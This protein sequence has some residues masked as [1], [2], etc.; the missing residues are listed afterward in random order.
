MVRILT[1]LLRLLLTPVRRLR[2]ANRPVPRK[3]QLRRLPWRVVMPLRTRQLH[4]RPRA[5]SKAPR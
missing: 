3:P 2:R 5:Q 1:L 4:H